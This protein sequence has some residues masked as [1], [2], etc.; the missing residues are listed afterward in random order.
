MGGSKS[1]W[2]R[3]WAAHREDGR[4]DRLLF[5]NSSEVQV[6]V[7]K[8]TAL[9][10]QSESVGDVVALG[11]LTLFAS[12]TI[13]SRKCLA[14]PCCPPPT[15]LGEAQPAATE[16]PPVDSP[17]HPAWP[18]TPSSAAQPAQLASVVAT[19]PVWTPLAKWTELRSKEPVFP[20]LF[21][22][23]G[24]LFASQVTMWVMVSGTV[25]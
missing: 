23:L 3:G 16:M 21:L 13:F 5:R 1:R 4:G 12:S 7:G 10:M 14:M 15:H 11:A 22:A 17:S 25:N 9:F 18:C 6:L 20:R 19:Q 24:G 8:A 2:R